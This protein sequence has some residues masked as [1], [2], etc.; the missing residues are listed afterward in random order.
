MSHDAKI[1]A[2]TRRRQQSTLRLVEEESVLGYWRAPTPSPMPQ[3]NRDAQA[4]GRDS[5]RQGPHGAQG[6]KV[7]D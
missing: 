3:T 1:K 5:N 2:F 6:C 4:R 7:E